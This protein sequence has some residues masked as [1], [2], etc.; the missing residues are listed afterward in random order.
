M[1]VTIE[2]QNEQEIVQYLTMKQQ[3]EDLCVLVRQIKNKFVVDG[4]SRALYQEAIINLGIDEEKYN[5]G[6]TQ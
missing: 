3:L 4:C 1:K 5:I 2:L 6:D